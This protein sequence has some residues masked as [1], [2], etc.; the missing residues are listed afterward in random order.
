MIPLF[1]LNAQHQQLQP[2]LN[3]V[4]QQ[5]VR[6]GQFILGPNVKALER[7]VA[8][9]CECSHAVGVASGTDA[10]RLALAAVGVGVGDEVITTPFTFIATASVILRAGA[11]P[12]F[13]DVDPTTLNLDS[14]AVASAITPRTKAIIVVH[15]YGNPAEMESLSDVAKK[16][17]LALIEDCAQAFGAEYRGKRVGSIGSVGC[18]SF[19]PTKNLGGVGD[20]GMVVTN[21]PT[22]ADRVDQLRRQGSRVRYIAEEVGFNSR[23]DELQAA[24]LRVK[25]EHIDGWQERRRQIASRYSEAFRSSRSVAVPLTHAPDSKPVFHLYTVKSQARAEL[26]RRLRDAGVETGV[27]YPQALHLQPAFRQYLARPLPVAEDAQDTVLSLPMFP[28]LTDA[29]IGFVID[30]VLDISR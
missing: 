29:E 23:L 14:S 5:V 22:I 11:V 2:R 12:V 30:S 8:I 15:L 16:H 21:E 19:Y 10:L 27:Y 17:G 9:A 4:L 28:E 1:N 6:D 20:G 7:E 13:V 25:L 18:L 26:Q 3:E 24:V